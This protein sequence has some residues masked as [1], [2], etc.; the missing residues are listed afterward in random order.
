M[1]ILSWTIVHLAND[2]SSIWGL[3]QSDLDDGDVELTILLNAFDDTFPQTVHS[4]TSY[5][6]GE[7][8]WNAKFVPI[9]ESNQDGILSLNMAGFSDFEKLDVSFE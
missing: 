7:I 8:V 1:L 3:K 4:R 5:Q 9:I 2:K 6:Y